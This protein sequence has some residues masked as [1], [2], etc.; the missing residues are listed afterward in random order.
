MHFSTPLNADLMDF[1]PLLNLAFQILHVL[2]TA[3]VGFYV[4]LTNKDKVTNDRITK[5]E[6]DV[7]MRLNSHS[8]RLARIEEAVQHAPTHE[9]LGELHTRINDV[10][11]GLSTLTGEVK[12]MHHTLNLIQQYLLNG[13]QAK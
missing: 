8:D 4:Y 13:G 5:L 6:N 2:A 10:A 1:F 7:D 3:A 11:T 9:H 12:G